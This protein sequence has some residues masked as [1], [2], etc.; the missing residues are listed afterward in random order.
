E[1][2]RLQHRDTCPLVRC[3]V[4]STESSCPTRFVKGRP[5]FPRFCFRFSPEPPRPSSGPP[6]RPSPSRFLRPS[7]AASLP[8]H[9]DPE[10]LPSPVVEPSRALGQRPSPPPVHGPPL[11]PRQLLVCPF[12]WRPR[13]LPLSPPPSPFPGPSP[14]RAR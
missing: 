5:S 8:A 1:A 9:P 3:S 10:Q 12:P 11:R 13:R 7:L 6:R 14:P 2:H 4:G